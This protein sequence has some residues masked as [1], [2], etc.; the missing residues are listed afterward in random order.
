[1]C[2]SELLILDFIRNLLYAP[3]KILWRSWGSDNDPF[4]N[5]QSWK[6][7]LFTNLCYSEPQKNALLMLILTLYR[8]AY[9]RWGVLWA[10]QGV[11]WSMW[12]VRF[13]FLS[14][15][16]KLKTPLTVSQVVVDGSSQRIFYKNVIYFVEMRVLSIGNSSVCASIWSWFDDFKYTF[17]QGCENTYTEKNIYFLLTYYYITYELGYV[18]LV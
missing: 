1:M 11:L 13:F 12:R 16:S 4:S 18:S 3:K 14:V 15:F 10:Y 2:R 7:L 9:E 8:I 6:L 5:F 17:F